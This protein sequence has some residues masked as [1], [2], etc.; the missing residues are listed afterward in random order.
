MNRYRTYL[1]GAVLAALLALPAV[2]GAETLP[3]NIGCSKP[4]GG[5]KFVAKPS[6]CFLD[7]DA[8]NP[9]EGLSLSEAVTLRRIK[10]SSWSATA[11]G[12]AVVRIKRNEP[13]I[14][15][16]VYAYKPQTCSGGDYR[17]FKVY[18]RVRVTFP[19]AQHTW[20]TPG[21]DA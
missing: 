12:T 16:K 10:W 19:Q 21:C 13:W 7:W 11:R 8:S 3:N 17:P 6:T 1:I 2:S 15:A 18:T 5:F 4:A 20:Q 14:K 9:D